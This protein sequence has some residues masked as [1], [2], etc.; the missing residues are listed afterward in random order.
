MRYFNQTKQHRFLSLT[1][2]ALLVLSL[3]VGVAWAVAYLVTDE[4]EN[5]FVSAQTSIEVKETFNGTTKTN[6]YV[7]NTG[8][9]ASPKGPAVYVRVKLLTYWY[10]A[11][12]EHIAAKS[13][14]TPSFTPGTDWVSIGGYYYYKKPVEAGQ[15]TSN[16][17][18]SITLTTDSDG[19]RQVLEIA[20]ESIQSDPQNAVTNAWG[21]KLDSNGYIT[22]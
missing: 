17:I 5:T 8:S 22:Q 19:N 11:G 1:L 20:A 10:A 9:T 13:S 12:G 14:W 16:L 21:V 7:A 3:G 4:V 6:M 18:S 2:I 15:N